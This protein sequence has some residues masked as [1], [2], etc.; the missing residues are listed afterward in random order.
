[1]DVWPK[2]RYTLLGVLGIRSPL[3]RKRRRRRR[4]LPTQWLFS[5][6]TKIYNTHKENVSSSTLFVHSHSRIIGKGKRK[7]AN[8]RMR[9]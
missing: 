7:G 9:H 4:Q 3:H 8:A 6:A 1:M 2:S 5:S